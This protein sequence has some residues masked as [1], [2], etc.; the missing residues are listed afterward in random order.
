M[1]TSLGEAVLELQVDV[2][3]LKEQLDKTKKDTE[4]TASK[5]QGAFNAV[6]GSAVLQMIAKTYK[7]L[8]A[9]GEEAAVT[10]A[11]VAAV[12]RATGNAAGYTVGELANMAD[13]FSRMTGFDDEV[14]MNAEAVLLTF[15]EIGRDVFP[16]A[17]KAA[18]DMSAV[19]G[20]D[21]QSSVVQLGKALNDPIQ[22]VTALRRVGVSF[23]D[24]QMAMIKS[25]V[26]TNDLLGAQQIVLD[27]LNAEFGGAA[28]EMEAASA[29]GK[30][31]QVSVGNLKEE[32]GKGMIPQ[33]RMWNYLLAETV[34]TLTENAAES[35]KYAE[36][37]RL[38]I[39]ILNQSGQAVIYSRAQFNMHREEIRANTAEILRWNEIGTYWEQRLAAEGAL[40]GELA[41]ELKEVDYKSLLDLTMNLTKENQNY[42]ASQEAVR[43]KQAEIKAEID[44]LIAGGYSPLSEKVLELQTDYTNLG[45]KYD[46]N[47][48]KHQ[49]ATNKILYDLL[50]TKLSVDGLTDAEYE[51]AL[52]AGLAFGQIDQEAIDTARNF[53]LVAQAVADGKIQVDQMKSALDL[54]PTLKNIDVVIDVIQNMSTVGLVNQGVP[55]SVAAQYGY[56]EGTGGWMQVPGGYP[57]DTYPIMVSSGELFSVI[58]NGGSQDAGLSGGMSLGSMDLAGVGGAGGGVNFIYSPMIST[59]DE[60]EARRVLGP[61]I[62]GKVREM[63]KR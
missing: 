5:I 48:V 38:A 52:Q 46:E 49:E 30:R 22:G 54:L 17:M 50:I 41:A 32:I 11:K 14:I 42:A 55:P 51:M 1:A 15:R 12:I 60:Y 8:I 59:A 23:T 34:D 13:D 40:V 4:S 47:A 18:M 33:Q 24:D 57:N 63:S 21:L 25:L 16:D 28:A 3:K 61:F 35:N 19:M 27:E 9:A 43:A 29:G 53:D 10:E 45:L 2:S 6:I 39:N 31:L 26:E 36:A 7:E 37:Q 44:A 56:A 58:P 62:E 20:T